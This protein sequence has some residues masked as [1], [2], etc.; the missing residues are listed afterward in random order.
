M[1]PRLTNGAPDI[2]PSDYC[3]YGYPF[4]PLK[5]AGVFVDLVI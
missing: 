3:W 4:L 5:W 2:L 1:S